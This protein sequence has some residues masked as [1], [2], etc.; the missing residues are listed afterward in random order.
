MAM[1]WNSLPA[2]CRGL[3]RR[4]QSARRRRSNGWCLALAVGIATFPGI[5]HATCFPPSNADLLALDRDTDDQPDRAVREVARLLG[6]SR[7]ARDALFRGELH[8][9]AAAAEVQASRPEKVLAHIEAGRLALNSVSPGPARSTLELSL[10]AAEAVEYVLVGKASEASAVLKRA[11]AGLAPTAPERSCL[12]AVRSLIHFQARSL[13]DAGADGIESFEIARGSGNEY[14]QMNAA[15]ILAAVY[16]RAGLLPQAEE[17]VNAA[18]RFAERERLAHLQTLIAFLEARVLTTRR[19]YPEGLVAAQRA[20]TLAQRSDSPMTLAAGRLAVCASLVDLKRIDEAELPCGGDDSVLAAAQRPDLLGELHAQRARIA[21]ARHRP[22]EAI[23][24]LDGVLRPGATPVGRSYIARYLRYRAAAHE[25]AGHLAQGLADVRQAEALEEQVNSEEHISA[26]AVIGATGER[27]RWLA[28][29][30]EMQAR[31]LVQQHEVDGH[32]LVRNLSVAFSGVALVMAALLAWL[33]R[34]SSRQRSELRRQ[35]AILSTVVNNVPD[36]LVLLDESGRVRFASHA[37]FGAQ[38]PP[39]VGHRLLDEVPESTTAAI[40]RTLDSIYGERSPATALA[41][42]EEQD[43]IVRYY[44]VHGAPIIERERLVGAVIQAMDV[45]ST[46]RLERE[47]VEASQR[48]RLRLASDL[49]EGLGQQLTGLSLLAKGL[50]GLVDQGKPVPRES[51]V[52]IHTLLSECIGT[53]RSA[54]WDLSPIAVER[55]SLG[56]A[57]RRLVRLAAPAGG[58]VLDASRVEEGLVLNDEAAEHL[59]RI[60]REALA[61]ALRHSGASQISFGLSRQDDE[62]TLVIAD[63]GRGLER[64]PEGPGLGLRMI[65]YRARLLGANVTIEPQQSGGTR[66]AVSVPWSTCRRA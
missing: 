14:A 20:N 23:A 34:Q 31:L 2:T 17:M 40:Q 48:E 39:P 42:S 33:L 11:M 53:V 59:Y 66:I 7:A 64:R 1:E 16:M 54:A 35:G 41:V 18:A 52:E 22:A 5:G 12:L 47:V 32:R 62:L 30:R 50:E 3:V 51:L 45:T 57:L 9:I 38:E 29:Q 56:D 43:G 25:A 4:E 6:E 24:L 15:Y 49:H 61:N 46:H 13:A 63:D 44:A 28:N 8:S 26:V 27:M 65:D 21:L 19:K 58:P 55:G 36:T 10:S 37:L 60:A